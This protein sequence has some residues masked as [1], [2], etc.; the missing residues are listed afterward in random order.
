MEQHHQHHQLQSQ[1]RLTAPV[2]QNQR[3]PRTERKEAK[4]PDGAPE[5]ENA[6]GG[7]QRQGDAKHGRV[8]RSPPSRSA[9]KRE[10]CGRGSDTDGMCGGRG[11]GSSTQTWTSTG[12]PQSNPPPARSRGRTREHN[13]WG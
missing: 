8:Q 9:Q 4:K 13:G 2:A 3:T 7:A 1:R 6:G 12:Y 10:G 11:E 5:K